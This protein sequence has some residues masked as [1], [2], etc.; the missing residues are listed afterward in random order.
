ML[1]DILGTVTQ[2]KKTPKNIQMKNDDT[3]AKFVFETM[4]NKCASNITINFI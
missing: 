1:H 2:K 3:F 4:P